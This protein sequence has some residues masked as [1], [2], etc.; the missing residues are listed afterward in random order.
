MRFSGLET[1]IEQLIEKL[2][3][4]GE[5]HDLR[6]IQS[7]DEYHLKIAVRTD[8]RSALALRPFSPR[9]WVMWTASAVL[10][11]DCRVCRVIS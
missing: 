6:F 10:T 11:E 4:H 7:E 5:D 2:N 3:R 8:S 9:M 1:E